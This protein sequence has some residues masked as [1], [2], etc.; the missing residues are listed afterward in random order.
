MTQKGEH[1]T[2]PGEN[3]DHLFSLRREVL[4][5]F[6]SHM[7]SFKQPADTPGTKEPR[8][9]MIFILEGSLD[10]L[11]PGS[12]KPVFELA[13]QQ[14]NILL[15]HHQLQPFSKHDV[16]H[17]VLIDIDFSFFSR[18]LPHDHPGFLNLKMGLT[19][20]KA[21]VFSKT[22]LHITPEIIGIL[23]ALKSSPH[24]GFCE[25][26]F[27]ESKVLELLVLQL[28]QYEQLINDDLKPQLKK[29]DLNKM[30]EVRKILIENMHNPLSLRTLSHMVGT[31]EFNLKRNFKVAFGNTV[32]GYLNQYKMEQAKTILLEKDITIAELAQSMGYK[33]AT[34]FSSAF[35]KYFGY[36][37]NKI[38][39][40][41]FTLIIFMKDIYAAYEEIF[42]FA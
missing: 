14:H 7:A 21:S 2:I 6:S 37:P 20:G 23:N 29:D 42:Q 11:L 13:N 33:Y 27:L 9:Q 41:N 15:G 34:H 22:N 16:H 1:L 19:Q 26:L 18:Y 38:R 28:S 5:R 25:K 8:L 31:N 12:R 10:Y 36:L 40:G 32:Y 17:L 24:T 30:H 35:K 3:T 4:I 39:T